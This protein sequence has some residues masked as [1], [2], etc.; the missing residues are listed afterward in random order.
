MTARVHT[1]VTAGQAGIGSLSS[2][3][4][5]M[6]RLVERLGLAQW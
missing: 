6:G 5:D 4:R 1:S 3:C 2:P